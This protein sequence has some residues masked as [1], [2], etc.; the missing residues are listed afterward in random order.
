MHWLDENWLGPALQTLDSRTPLL[1]DQPADEKAM[2]VTGI[3][4]EEEHS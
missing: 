1:M 2:T 3:R 4:T